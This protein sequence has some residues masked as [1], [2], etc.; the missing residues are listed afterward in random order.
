MSPAFYIL[1]SLKL[2]KYYTGS[3]VDIK[4]RFRDHNAGN[5][6]FTS[7]GVPWELKYYEFYPTLQEARKREREV[8]RKKSRK[9][10]ESLTSNFNPD[11]T[12]LM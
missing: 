3:C 9:F 1:Y 11:N 2:D 7:I 8:K 6:T 5:S 12:L 4:S 10:I